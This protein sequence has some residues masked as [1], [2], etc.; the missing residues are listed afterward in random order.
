MTSTATPPAGRLAGQ[1][2]LLVGAT[3]MVGEPLAKALATTNEV[4]GVARF[5]NP[6]AQ[7]RLE[8]AGVTCVPFDL[9]SGDFATLPDDI[10]LVANFAVAHGTDWDLDLAAN[11]EAVGL[12]MQRYAS[13]SA[14]LHCSSTAVYQPAGAAPRKETDPLGDNHRGIMET[15]SIVKIAAEAVARTMA[16]A[17]R[18][19]TTIARLN[20]PYGDRCGFPFFHLEMMRAG[21]AIDL[22]P[23]RPERVLPA[24]R[25]RHRPH[26]AGAVRGG[27][28]PGHDRQLGRRRGRERG[29]MVRLA[30]RA[31]GARGGFN[32]NPAMVGSV[33]PDLTR[34]HE[35]IGPTTVHWRDGLRQMVEA[36][37]AGRQDAHGG[38]GAM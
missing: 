4:I 36:R 8:A 27:V 33:V 21:M 10:D 5:S 32:D 28:G 15:Y 23:D 22:H 6:K 7:A 31:L 16:R 26:G 38:P 17:E 11:A 13:A 20:L 24:A 12:L 19:P 29:G 3:G 37:S 9:L 30:R 14:F 34:M 2:I 18:L 1:R 35:L 25:G